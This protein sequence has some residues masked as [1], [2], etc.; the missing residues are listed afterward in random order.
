[1]LKGL[2][3]FTLWPELKVERTSIDPWMNSVFCPI[4]EANEVLVRFFDGMTIVRAYII[5]HERQLFIG[6]DRSEVSAFAFANS[7]CFGPC[8]LLWVRNEVDVVLRRVLQRSTSIYTLVCWWARR[9]PVRVCWI[10]F[11]LIIIW[12]DCYTGFVFGFESV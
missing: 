3:R 1:M 7:L 6:M 11:S 2:T 4:I 10:I 12:V 8:L 5:V 9:V